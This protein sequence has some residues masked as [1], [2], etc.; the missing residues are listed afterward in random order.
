MLRGNFMQQ[1]RLRLG[2]VLDDYCPRERR[3]TN[4]V[5][6]AIVEDDV[7]QTRCTTCDAEH[8]YRRSKAPAAR[9]PKTQGA[10]VAEAPDGSRP[11]LASVTPRPIVESSPIEADDFTAEEPLSPVSIPPVEDPAL[12]APP[13][14][15]AEARTPAPEAPTEAV[16]AAP[17]E[18][19]DDDDGP[20]HR[21]LI[22]ATFP[23]PEGHIP[24]RREPEFTVRQPGSRGGR[25]EVD[26]NRAGFRGGQQGHGYGGGRDFGGRPHGGGF[27]ADGHRGGRGPG[28]RGGNRPGGG[29]PNRGQ[30][31]GGGAG[32][33]GGR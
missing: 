2:D 16:V 28:G 23:R 27:G 32:R 29:D 33:K 11:H 13:L 26:G 5:V 30:R 9:R 8:V 20:V 21:P 6:V 17:T 1:R 15:M 19:R 31:Q 10:L 24:E 18:S 25:G 22:R 7:R 4:H 14:L 12:T 3:V